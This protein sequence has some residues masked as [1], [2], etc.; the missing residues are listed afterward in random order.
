MDRVKK[1][2]MQNARVIATNIFMGISVIAIV[3]VLMLI[4]MGFNFSD[5]GGIEQSGL[6]QI[7]S[8][9]RGATVEIDGQ[10]QFNRTNMSKML[11][12]TSHH[13]KVTKNGYD[14]W[15]KDLVV[16]A[17]LLTRIEWIRLFPT[18]PHAANTAYFSDIRLAE[19]SPD[20]KHLLIIEHDFPY[21][22]TLNIQDDK[23][24]RNRKLSLNTILGPDQNV[25]LGEI[26]IR[27]WNIDNNK[28]VLTWATETDT[29]WYLVDLENEKNAINLSEKFQL[30]F[31]DIQIANDGATKLWALEN[32]RL[33][34][35]N[36]NELTISSVIFSDVEQFASN[37]GVVTYIATN[38]K[39]Q[40]RRVSIYQDGEDG[41]TTIKHLEDQEA[42]ISLAMGDYWNQSWLVLSID[43][44]LEFYGGTYPSYGK[45]SSFK[46]LLSKDLEFTPSLISVNYT[47]RIVAIAGESQYAAID[48]ETNDLTTAAFDSEHSGIN[49]LDDYLFWEIID[50]KVVVRDFDG[51][52]RREILSDINCELPVALLLRH[53][54]A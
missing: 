23:V 14:T 43:N 17:G 48:V 2:K 4:A 50:K 9:P 44:H 40:S 7:A 6:V 51:S 46:E 24:S 8:S 12:S 26:T 39:D 27:D 32:N 3:L 54:R 25:L 10:Q 47:G 28:V 53:R 5:E 22:S 15:E 49:W 41:P 38:A 19:F 30:D 36:V 33:H 37:S 1:K 13:V 35:I 34:T 29:N 21:L 45:K 42:T 18:A 20:R 31:E 52:N 16:D 11:S